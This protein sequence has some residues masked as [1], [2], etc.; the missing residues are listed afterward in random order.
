MREELAFWPSFHSNQ[1][2]LQASAGSAHAESYWSPGTLF[3]AGVLPGNK[4][5]S[6]GL[7]EGCHPGT[8]GRVWYSGRSKVGEGRYIRTEILAAMAG[9]RKAEHALGDHLGPN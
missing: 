4:T 1:Q 2:R 5:P 6:S 9:I 7:G 8:C 3:S